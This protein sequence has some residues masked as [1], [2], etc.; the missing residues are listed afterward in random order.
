MYDITHLFHIAVPRPEVFAR[1]QTAA[2]IAN[3][4]TE[5][6]V[7]EGQVGGQL[8]FRFNGH[9]LCRVEVLEALTDTCISWK[10]LEGHPDWVGT[11]IKFELSDNEGKT[12]I[13]FSHRGFGQQDDHFAQCNFSWGRYMLS[14]RA[15][16]EEGKGDPWPMQAVAS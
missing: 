11:E 15:L 8:E 7:G 9:L 2:A 6:T 1:L 10:V 3:W 5:D 16:C 14:L 4:W 12:R 13:R